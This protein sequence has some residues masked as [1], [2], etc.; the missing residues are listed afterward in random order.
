MLSAFGRLV[1]VP[2][3]GKDKKRKMK[4]YGRRI[5]AGAGLILGLLGTF[6]ISFIFALIISYLLLS[7]SI[8][9]SLYGKTGR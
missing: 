3:V 5:Y 1:T 2:S 8:L 4:K 7:L 9:M 6:M